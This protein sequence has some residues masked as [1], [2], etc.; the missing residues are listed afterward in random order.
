MRLSICVGMDHPDKPGDDELT[1]AISSGIVR[2][3]KKSR[4]SRRDFYMFLS[5]RD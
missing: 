1:E 5:V 2:M 3:N 4:L